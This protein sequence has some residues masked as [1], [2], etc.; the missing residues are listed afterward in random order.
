MTHENERLL[1]LKVGELYLKGANRPLFERRLMDH[2]G[3]VVARR[4]ARA[5][6]YKGKIAVTGAGHDPV[7]LDALRRVFG[8]VSIELA[9]AVPTDERA[10][11]AA[12][13]ELAAGEVESAAG[14]IRTFRIDARR[15]DK[16]FGLESIDINRRAGAAVVEATGLGVDLGDPDLTV[17]IEV[18]TPRSYLYTRRVAGAGGLPRHSAGRA[19]LLL[20]GGIDSPVAGWLAMRRGLGIEAVHFHSPPH[21][22]P[23][24]VRK[25]R[26]LARLLA[27]YQGGTSL[28]LVPFTSAQQSVRDAVREDYRV[29]AYRRMMMRVAGRLASRR[30]AGALVTGE[31]LSQVASQTLPNLRCVELATELPVLRPLVTYDKSEVV[32]RARELGT[33]EVSIRPGEDCCSLFVPAHPVTRGRPE[34]CS[35]E[36]ERLDVEALVDECVDGTR[37]ELVA[38]R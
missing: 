3:E 38:D 17:R 10:I 31:S 32:E 12:A 33:Y 35:A 11:L 36:E 34:T 13:V 21:T 2:L 24:A 7:L 19:L 37:T 27:S 5:R 4:G 23:A 20:S 25:A 1:L 15:T 29:L 26:D 9:T 18:D 16:R 8:I 6:S 30:A 28:H 14:R 22:G